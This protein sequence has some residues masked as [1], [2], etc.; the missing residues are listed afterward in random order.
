METSLRWDSWLT[1]LQAALARGFRWLP[2][3]EASEITSM[4]EIAR[5]EGMDF[6]YVA[7]LL[8]LTTLCPEIITAILG[9]TLLTHLTV[10]GLAV[11]T[12]LL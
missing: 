12:P 8:N 3:L 10:H 6:S 9:D 11:N 7:R 1:A 2:A 5:R 4:S